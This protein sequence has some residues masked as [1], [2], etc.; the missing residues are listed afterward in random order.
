MKRRITA[1]IL[2]GLLLA[3]PGCG[4]DKGSS[5]DSASSNSTNSD[6]AGASASTDSDQAAS[7]SKTDADSQPAEAVELDFMFADGDENAKKAMN[8]MVSS[9]NESQTE[10]KVNIV[11]GTAGSYDEVLKTKD[12]VGEFPDVMEM[13]NPATYIRADKLAPI[14]DEI[15]ALF[16]STTEINGAVY[17]APMGGENTIGIIYNKTYFDENGFEEPKTYDEF[18]TLCQ[19]IKD[20]GDMAPLVVGGQDL[21]HLG[22]WYQKVYADQVLSQNDDFIKAC[23]EGTEDFS[24]DL[25][26]SAFEEMGTIFQYAQDGWTSTPDAQITTFLVNDMAAMMYSGTHMFGQ[27]QQ[28]DPD[29]EYGWFP[30]PSPDGKLRLVGGA[31]ATGLSISKDCGA[32][33]EKL[34]ATVKFMQYFFSNEPY[35]TF[36]ETLAAIPTTK[37]QPDMEVDA[38]FQEVIDAQVQ[39]DELMPFWNSR[40]GDNE[41]TPGFRDF[42]YK[43]LV[44][45]LTGQREFDSCADEMNAFWN[46]SMQEFNPITGVGVE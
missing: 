11:T 14:P 4:A 46:T 6:S 33:P 21:W 3:L 13:K 7:D 26:K 10:V 9:F 18:I 20:K 31:A 30:V 8:Q 45:Y 37:D 1:L 22:F 38:I 43:T 24:S 16:T 39:A 44:E 35:G 5:A 28:A 23:Y 34:A 17:T 32:D 15:T 25:V 27:I 19:S 42:L 12:T 29:F 41:V 40:V 36:C 2:A